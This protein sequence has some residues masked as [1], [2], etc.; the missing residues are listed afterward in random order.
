METSNSALTNTRTTK[1]GWIAR[2]FV[3]PIRV[4]YHMEHHLMAS[5]PYFKLPKM[6]QLLRERGYAPEPP[7]YRQ[8]M[9]LLSKKSGQVDGN[10]IAIGQS[11]PQGH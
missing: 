11:A 10:Q 1:A 5:V 7:T 3:A 6:H 4:N 8:V 9:N 2:A